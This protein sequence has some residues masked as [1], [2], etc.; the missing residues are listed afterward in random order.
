MVS[1]FGITVLDSRKSKEIDLYSD[2]TKNKLQMF[3]FTAITSMWIRV[4][5]WLTMFTMD[6]QINQGLVFVQRLLVHK[7]MK[8]V[9]LKKWQ[10][11]CLQCKPLGLQKSKDFRIPHE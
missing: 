2:Y 6:W 10:Q 8:A 7:H 3:T 11:F 9:L 1:S 5:I 4:E